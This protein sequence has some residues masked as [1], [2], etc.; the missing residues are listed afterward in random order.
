MK[1]HRAFF[2]KRLLGLCVLRDSATRSV[3]L[4]G[5]ANNEYNKRVKAFLSGIEWV[6][7]C[8]KLTASRLF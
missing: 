1:G 2:K 4:P 5:P 8:L 7:Q 3:R 6:A